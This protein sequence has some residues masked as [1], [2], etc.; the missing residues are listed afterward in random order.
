MTDQNDIQ[1]LTYRILAALA[2]GPHAATMLQTLDE[3]P[4]LIMQSVKPH[5]K[6]AKGTGSGEPER[7][8]DVLRVAVRALHAMHN[9]PGV[10]QC[11]Q[12]THIY[13]RVLQT[14]IMVKMLKEMQE[15]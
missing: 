14:E 5:L 6:A 2:T 10:E 13:L 9:I 12:Y 3:L 15:N 8:K 4:P 11:T 1:L 7:A